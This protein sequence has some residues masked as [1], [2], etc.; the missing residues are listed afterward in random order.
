MRP[1]KAK[2]VDAVCLVPFVGRYAVRANGM[3]TS[4]GDGDGD[5]TCTG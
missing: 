5:G 4:N 2:D 3:G 1:K